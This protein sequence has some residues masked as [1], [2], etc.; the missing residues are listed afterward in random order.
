MHPWNG[1]EADVKSLQ[2][3][4]K[5]VRAFQKDFP[6]GEECRWVMDAAWYS[7]ENIEKTG[8]CF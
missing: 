4:M 5:G 1:N 6:I 7:K 3:T 2:D 8:E